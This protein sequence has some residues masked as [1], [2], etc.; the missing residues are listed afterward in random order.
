MPLKLDPHMHRRILNGLVVTGIGISA[1]ALGLVGEVENQTSSNGE[2]NAE[3]GSKSVAAG[4]TGGGGGKP[5]SDPPLSPSDRDMRITKSRLET[6]IDMMKTFTELN[7]EKI[8]GTPWKT[9]L[10]MG[11]EGVPEQV[12]WLFPP[13]GRALGVR[14]EGRGDRFADAVAN[15]AGEMM[16]ARAR[17]IFPVLNEAVR[18]PA[19]S[20]LEM[21][22][23]AISWFRVGVQVDTFDDLRRMLTE[24]GSADED[25]VPGSA[26]SQIDRW[27]NEPDTE[28]TELQVVMSSAFED[29]NTS[30][31]AAGVR[32]GEEANNPPVPEDTPTRPVIIHD[33][34]GKPSAKWYQCKGLADRELIEWQTKRGFGKEAGGRM[35]EVHGSLAKHPAWVIWQEGAPM[36]TLTYR[37]NEQIDY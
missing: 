2:R 33:V 29:L 17:T 32:I 36:K 16:D 6:R 18:G 23:G 24:V 31:L 13:S 12:G 7:V 37:F 19:T 21:I 34:L 15:A 9:I 8:E 4:G 11:L 26:A 20:N 14:L 1:G 28:P 25:G 5:P 30:W 27:E 10:N 22:L 3:L 35:G